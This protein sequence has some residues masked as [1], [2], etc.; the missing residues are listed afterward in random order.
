MRDPGQAQK[1]RPAGKSGA[2]PETATAQAEAALPALAEHARPWLDA[3]ASIVGGCCEIGPGTH[4][5]AAWRGL[6]IGRFPGDLPPGNLQALSQ[7]II[8]SSFLSRS[9]LKWQIWRI[10]T[11][12][13]WTDSPGSP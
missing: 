7:D 8:L 1:C 6:K 2:R 12:L 10:D 9:A 4:R 13:P 11:L 5:R 3:G